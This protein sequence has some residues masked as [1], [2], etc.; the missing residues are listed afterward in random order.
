M[1]KIRTMVRTADSA[2]QRWVETHP[3]LAEEYRHD[4]KLK[5]DPRVTRLG[6]FLRRSSID[7]LPQLWNVFCGQMSLVGPRPIVW[8]ELR[9]YGSAAEEFLTAR[10]GVTGAWQVN[11]R[12]RISY[13]ARAAL[14]LDYSRS[15]RF[16]SDLRLLVKTVAV[17]TRFDGL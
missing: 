4:F 9:Y 7:E 10:P 15:I 13:P 6:R 1:W 5:D 2:M 16:S 14:E 12:N 3:E 17:P 11:G 8:D